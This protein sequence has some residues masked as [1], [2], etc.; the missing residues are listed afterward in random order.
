M[1]S[2]F[3]LV[4]VFSIIVFLYTSSYCQNVRTPFF[5]EGDRICFLGNSITHGGQYHEFIQL[6]YAT[7]YPELNLTFRNCGISGDVAAGM[8]DRL[9][10]DVFVHNPTHVFLMVGMNDVVRTLYFEGNA[11]DQILKKRKQALELYFKKTELLAL[12]LV[13]N[14]VT[15][16]FLT[17]SIYDQYSKI[18]KENNL[19]CNDA[20]ILCAAHINELAKKYK[21]PVVNLNFEM[22]KIMD[23]GLVKDSLFTIIGKDRVHPG[24]LGHIVI[25]DLI[26]STLENKSEVSK[27][28]INLDKSKPKF[29]SNNGLLRELC[30]NDREISFKYKS[31]TLPFPI[32]LEGL[33]ASEY[34]P[35]L[36]YVNRETLKINKLTKGTYDVFVQDIHIGA[37]T[38]QELEKGVCLNV[39]SRRPEYI[40]AKKVLKNCS[41]YR[42]IGYQLRAVPFIKYRYL[43]DYKGRQNDTEIKHFLNKKLKDIEGE[44]YYMYIQKSMEE[45]FEIKPN[46]DDLEKYILYL[47][48]KIHTSRQLDFVNFRL[49]KR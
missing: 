32:E 34:A 47:N 14:E 2:V 12:E 15:P 41:D 38:S 42:K 8:L 20:L 46:V 44:S 13:K 4:S 37:C 21:A 28:E 6:F 45:Y 24:I 22:K 1:R 43:M 10:T 27:I 30:V 11:S 29:K 35:F 16:I 48:Y 5:K 25:S 26:L 36:S 40:E 18:E 49:V 3:K 19:G 7:K 9:K 39:D 33:G 23:K 31:E 17:P